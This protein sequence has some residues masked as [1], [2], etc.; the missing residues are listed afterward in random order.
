M[1]RR[2]PIDGAQEREYYE[3][4][5]SG[6]DAV[7]LLVCDAEEPVGSVGLNGLDHHNGVAEIGIFL[8][9]D[10]QGVGLGTEAAR[11]VTGYA[12]AELRLHR[13]LARVLAGNEA[14]MRVWE[15][16]GYEHEGVH[17][18]AA[19]VDGEHVDLHHYGGSPTGGTRSSDEVAVRGRRAVTW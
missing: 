3:S 16:L 5:V 18:E 2:S 4:V 19:F 1:V 17:R 13:V 7:T 10:H 14:P 8:G 12:F 15:T 6:D 11:L 9:T